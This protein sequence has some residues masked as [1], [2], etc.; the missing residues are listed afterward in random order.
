MPL[1]AQLVAYRMQSVVGSNST[2]GSSSFFLWKNSPL[3]GV[4]GVFVGLLPFYL[5]VYTYV[6]TQVLRKK[7]AP[8]HKSILQ[9]TLYS[10][11]SFLS[12]MPDLI[13][14]DDA[15]VENKDDLSKHLVS[16]VGTIWK[17]TARQP[18]PLLWEY[19]QVSSR[20]SH[21]HPTVYTNHH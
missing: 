18:R 6:Y 20:A 21:Y 7:F 14:D 9:F 4:V 16:E 12:L 8:D 5:I 17:G 13:I 11:N 19:G 3:L 1:V 15:Y 2:Q 10:L